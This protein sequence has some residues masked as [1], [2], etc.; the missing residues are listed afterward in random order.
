MATG[1]VL[2]LGLSIPL[3][4]AISFLY[5]ALVLRWSE[6]KKLGAGA[7]RASRANAV[8]STSRELDDDGGREAHLDGDAARP[9]PDDVEPILQLVSGKEGAK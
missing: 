4:M 2:A 7:N 6:R 9:H 3:L 8:A 5:D 1:D